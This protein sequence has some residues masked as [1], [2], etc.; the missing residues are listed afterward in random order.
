MMRK[1][2]IFICALILTHLLI[3]NA[4]S[5]IIVDHWAVQEFEQ[6]PD[7][8]IEKAKELTIHYG[9]TSHGSQ[10]LAGLY[11]IED[12]IDAV[13]YKVAIGPRNGSRSPALPSSTNPAS[14]RLW[15][16][17]LWPESADGHLGYWSGNAALQ[18]TKDIL[19][20][21]IFDVSGWAWCG[22]VGNSD[23]DYIQ[24]Y[25]NA[26][27]SLVAEYS[28]VKIFYMTGHNV[29]PGPPNHK[30]VAWDRLRS[31]NNGIKDHCLEN[32]GIL[33][34]F[35]DIETHDPDGNYY[36][37]ED[38]TGTWCAAWVANHPNEYPNLPP[39]TES[40]C[41]SG[42]V[43][44]AHAHGLFT[45]IKA[46]AFWWMM[47]R[48]AGWEGVVRL[49]IKEEGLSLNTHSLSQNY[50]NPFNPSTT[51][52]FSLAKSE[53]V[54][55]EVYNTLGKKVK[56][57]VDGNMKAGEHTVEFNAENLSSGIYF[58]SIEAGEFQSVKKMI[59]LK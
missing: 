43:I 7:E 39:R 22:Q 51:I 16:E 49:S 59:V 23:W 57:L 30:Q 2:T 52:H 18:G 27:T 44:S 10:I 21:G 25:L 34:D 29:E 11:W 4:S 37:D 5:Q 3:L 38:G 14:L 33:F 56:V 17:G 47:A 6:I 19:N 8:W 13:K 53:N 35:A 24:G 50:P 40:G 36:P 45:V 32:N 31:N 58:Y 46:K 20:T 1:I 54:Q 26:L 12:N 28:D 48:I 15:E 41:G 42:C 55:I 9:H